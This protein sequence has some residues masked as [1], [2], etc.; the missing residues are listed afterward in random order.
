MVTGPRAPVWQ[1]ES[2]APVEAAAAPR[3]CRAAPALR[4]TRGLIDRIG[5]RALYGLTALAALLATLARRR[6][7]SGSSS[8]RPGRRSASA[9]ISFVWDKTWQLPTPGHRAL[10]RP[11]VPHRHAR[12]LVRRDADRG[13]ALD[14]DRP[15]PQRAR[16]AVDPRPDRLADRHARRGSERRDRP[17]GDPRARAVRCTA[18]SS[19]GCT[20]CSAS[21][22]SS[23]HPP[24]TARACSR[25]SIVLAIMATPIISSI[26]RELFVERA[27]ASSR[28]RRSG[29]ARR[30]GRWCEAS[31]LPSVRG[32]VVAAIDPR[33]RP[34]ARRGDRRHAGD[35]QRLPAQAQPLR[36][37]ATRSRASIAN[38]YSEQR[39]RR[40][41]RASLIY[42]GLILLV[43]TFIDELHRPADRPSLRP[44]A[45]SR[46][47]RSVR[48]RPRRSRRPAA[49]GAGG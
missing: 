30:A 46:D 39:S 47:E 43:I 12:H 32:G 27:D 1:L 9:G 25:R 4:R 18:R 36:S 40:C 42:L 37:P 21:S 22:R 34:R 19:R 48:R 6:R 13:A 23:A 41:N 16:P 31:S 10:R 33:A 35:R 5:D 17:L 26:C 28:R 8:S 14:R 44:L 2:Y 15:L 49:R 24:P 20:T 38:Q 11:R 45:A 7:S 29:S 3:P